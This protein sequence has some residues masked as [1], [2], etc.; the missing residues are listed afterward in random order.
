N[1]NDGSPSVSARAIA[2]YMLSS[3]DSKPQPEIPCGSTHF[4][5]SATV[6]PSARLAVAPSN[7]IHGWVIP[8]IP[9][10]RSQKSVH[11][12]VTSSG[13]SV[14]LYLKSPSAARSMQLEATSAPASGVVSALGQRGLPL[15]VVVTPI[16]TLTP[17]AASGF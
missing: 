12:D 9:L 8:S 4:S 6:T 14:P 13:G 16:R 2:L 17:A 10:V 7:S 1:P 3:C 11:T 5:A 15:S